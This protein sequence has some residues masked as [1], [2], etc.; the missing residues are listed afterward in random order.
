MARPALRRRLVTG[1]VLA[2]LVGGLAGWRIAD[3]RSAD[4]RIEDRLVDSR[5]PAG[6][7]SLDTRLYLPD[8]VSAS[9]PAP[10]VL[11]AHGFGG[12]KLSVRGDAADLADRGYVV[13]TY[14]ARGFGRSTGLIGLNALDGEVADARNLITFLGGRPEVARDGAGD[15]RVGIAG[16]SY[17]GALALM[18]A[19]TDRR[20]DAIVPQI[21]WNRLSRVFFPNGAGVPQGGG[22][23]SPADS[24]ASPG[25]FKREWAGIFF[26]VGKD[27]DPGGLPG[28]GS[29][30]GLGA[31]NGAQNGAPDG[32]Q[33]GRPRGSG[34][35]GATAGEG[36]SGSEEAL[37]CGRFARDICRVYTAAAAT[38]TLDEAARRRLDASSPWSVAGAVTAPTFLVQGEED[39]LFP[40]SEADVTARQIRGRGTPVAV[41]WTAG[42]H[43][44]GGTTE[45]D[46][47]AADLR[48]DI[49]A[50]FDH[51]LRRN[52]PDPSSSP[53]AFAFDQQ[54]GLSSTRSRA[55]TRTR[56]AAS[57]PLG[58][59]VSTARVA[60]SGPEQP[61]VRP[62]GGAPASLSSLP[63]VGSALGS[64][65]FDPPGQA[66]LF[67]TAP[68]DGPVDVVGSATVSFTI[69]GTARGAVLFAKVYD[70]PP[71]GRP[72]LPHG[73]VVPFSVPASADATTVDVV[74]PALAHRFETGH[75]MVVAVATTDRAYAS[76][77]FQQVVRVA[78]ADGGLTVRQVPSEASGSDTSPWLW[79]ALAVAGLAA[80]AALAVAVWSRLGLR[81]TIAD[82]DPSLVDVPVAVDGLAKEYADGFVAVRSADLRVERDQV[83][84]LLGPNGAGKT[85]TLR[86]LMGLIRPTQGTIR[87]FG[88][89]VTPGAPVLSRMGCF[90]EG[91]GFLPHLSGRANLTLYWASTGRPEADARLEEV[92][93]IA[94]LGDAIERPV[95]TYSQGMRQR[96]AIAQAMLGLPELLVLD[97][98][99][100]G[101]DPPQI[102]EMRE[103]LRGYAV[104]GRSV[105]LSSHQLAEVEQTCSHVVVMDRG[106]V[107]ASGTVAQVSAAVPESSRHRLEDAFLA[108]IGTGTGTGTGTGMSTGT[109]VR[110]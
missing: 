100:N 62:A 31:L 37:V 8:G 110:S 49:A 18:A 52:G 58:D 85:T 81:R 3:N 103:V 33:N 77:S 25:A 47:A 57:Y 28:V 91:V 32:A 30:T 53:A 82:T 51:H 34:T 11:L 80:L 40:L 23:A 39:T 66:A 21:T 35:P 2:G 106:T 109:G 72:R 1:A 56:T 43:D 73:Q 71:D 42:G 10:A 84:G 22:P 27:L 67:S 105:L 6:T 107:I 16:E 92:L 14:S 17:G 68:L 36:S 19:G 97:E 44:A 104:A 61:V 87:V 93:R 70:V 13:L 86:M 65:A 96:L 89:A 75:R 26:G 78:L 59:E 45:S 95:R 41:R 4:Y 90:V 101:L 69:A 83:V 60:L 9:S 76:P 102:A 15:P 99:T 50:W 24:D 7:V 12:T 38:G 108:M 94:G 29:I 5:T 54:T 64:L 79:L 46:A 20:V 48:E 88:H 55:T 63:G 98:P 74:L